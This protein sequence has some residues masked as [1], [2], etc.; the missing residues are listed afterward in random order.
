MKQGYY[1]SK[2]AECTGQVYC[3]GINNRQAGR[4]NRKPLIM[5]AVCVLIAAAIIA[6]L[7]G[8]AAAEEME[9]YAMVRDGDFVNVRAS[10]S[11]RSESIGRLECGDMV[12]TDGVTRGDWVHLIR[13]SLESAEGWVHSGY[14]VTEKPEVLSWEKR[15]V[16]ANGRVAC[17]KWADGPRRAWAKNGS[18][19]K[20]YAIG[21]G[22]ALTNRGYIAED[23]LEGAE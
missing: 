2:T 1:T 8:W 11:R 3:Y 23:Y 18:A 22:W 20:V 7:I 6:A 13:L 10:A 16:R 19:V 14:L 12:I 15:T 4:K 17:R 21:G 5:M 9:L